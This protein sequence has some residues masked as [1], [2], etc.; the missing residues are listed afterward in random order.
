MQSTTDYDQF[1]FKDE[2]RKIKNDHLKDIIESIKTCNL[3]H[4][5]PITVNE[6]LEIMDG[7][8]RFIAAR[9][10]NLP[11]FYKIEEGIESN[12]MLILNLSKSWNNGDYLNY[13]IQ[14]GNQEYVKLQEFIKSQQLKLNVALNL[15]M[16]N[17]H[18]SRKN[19]REGKFI[20]NQEFTDVQLA[21]CRRTQDI[22][23]RNN[24]HSYYTEA[25]KFWRALITLISHHEFD[26]DKWV[27]NLNHLCTRFCAK[28]TTADYLKLMTDVYNWRNKKRI[29]LNEDDL[30]CDT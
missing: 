17:S 13:Y 15:V 22:I 27:D 4:M 3:L 2:N 6:N 14:K 18:A 5:R 11:I 12:Q 29:H 8:H 23:T 30:I 7:Q 28:A 24:G 21:N 20:L 9:T 19:F 16:G 1:I 10:L 26:M 25:A